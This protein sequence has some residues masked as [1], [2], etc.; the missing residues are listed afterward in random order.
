MPNPLFLHESEP[1][2]SKCGDTIDDPRL[3]YLNLCSY[4]LKEDN[5]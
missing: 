4:C 2:C 1:L 5:Q 3:D